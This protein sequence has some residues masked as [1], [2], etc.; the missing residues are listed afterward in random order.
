MRKTEHV[1]PIVVTGTSVGDVHRKI[2]GVGVV[3]Y[4]T[5]TTVKGIVVHATNTSDFRKIIEEFKKN[6]D[7]LLHTST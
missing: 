2:T 5:N 3:N 7:A 6:F 1:P 4:T